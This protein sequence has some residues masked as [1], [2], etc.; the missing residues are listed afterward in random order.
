[1]IEQQLAAVDS[2]LMRSAEARFMAVREAIDRGRD[3]SEVTEKVA[4]AQQGLAQAGDALSGDGL[5]P[6]ATLSASFFILFREGLEALLVVAALLT[7]TRKANAAKA[8]RHIHYGWI[9]ALVAGGLT[10]YV[11]N[12]LITFSGAS[13]EM[14]EGFAGVVAALILFYVG[15]WMHSNSNS[16]KWMGYIKSKVD[17][18]LGSGTIWVLAFVS[19]I[20]V[21]REIFETIL[22]YEALLSQV[23]ATTQPYLFYGMGAAILA[24]AVVFPVLPHWHA[25]AAESVLPRDQHCP[26]DPVGDS[27]WQRHCRPAGS[28]ADQCVL[29]GRAH[30][31]VVGSLPHRARC[32]RTISGDYPGRG[33]LAAWASRP[34]GLSTELL[35]VSCPGL[36]EPP[37][38]G[39]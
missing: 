13:R 16:Q 15:F 38:G 37:S 30:H 10:W 19:F 23:T 20:S 39:F 26:A 3:A 4:A 1:M 24:L 14:T 31:R 6:A 28:R 35:R 22:F 29:S 27:A 9:M 18:A 32:G 25:L 34:V 21:Y 17:N 2:E 8:T 5:S 12:T 33:F 7:F 11:A 36:K